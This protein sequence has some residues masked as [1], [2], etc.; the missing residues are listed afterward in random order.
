MMC[1][2]KKFLDVIRLE[3]GMNVTL[4]YQEGKKANTVTSLEL[5]EEGP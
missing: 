3:P 2:W 4:G 1:R 5:A